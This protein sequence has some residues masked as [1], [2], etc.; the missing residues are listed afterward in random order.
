MRGSFITLE[1]IKGSGKSTQ[2]T[3]LGE[4]LTKHNIAHRLVR[5]PGSTA[6]GDKIRELILSNFSLTEMTAM[7]EVL[8]YTAARSQLV[9]EHIIPAIEAGEV[10]ICDR[11]IDSS[12]VYQGYAADIDPITIRKINDLVFDKVWP[13]R[14]YLLDVDV[15]LSQQRLKS[16]GRKVDRM[17]AR[18][19]EF[20]ERVRNGYLHLAKSEPERYITIDATQSEATITTSIWADMKALLGAI[21]D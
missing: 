8:L 3:L 7:T 15:S 9:S 21:D 4:H 20:Q 2:L 6:L 16:R 13:S 18:E 5:D 1:G 19:I 12:L 14:T 10:V 11:Y 17:E